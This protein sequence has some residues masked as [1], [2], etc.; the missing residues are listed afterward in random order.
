MVLHLKHP[1]EDKLRSGV[2]VELF[3]TGTVTCPVNAFNKWKKASNLRQNPLKPVF[4]LEHG[5]CL[6]G[7]DFNENVKNLLEK[8]INYEE[9]RYSSHSFRSVFASMMAAAGFKDE[10]IMHQGRWHSEA[11]LAYCRTGRASRLREQRDIAN[12]LTKIIYC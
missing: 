4:C 10:E 12:R 11:F 3:G 8:Y 6:T 1:K 9:K 5:K 7:R 2:N